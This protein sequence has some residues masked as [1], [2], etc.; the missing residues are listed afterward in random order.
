MPEANDE[1]ATKVSTEENDGTLAVRTL[2]K[3]AQNFV[4][5]LSELSGI[6]N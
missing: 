6:L 2:I 4:A 1:T 5:K 3:I